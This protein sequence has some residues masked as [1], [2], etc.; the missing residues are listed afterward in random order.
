VLPG[1]DA[2]QVRLFPQ[3]FHFQAA[4][5][6]PATTFDAPLWMKRLTLGV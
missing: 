3:L 4:P 6:G 2:A 1:V 5:F